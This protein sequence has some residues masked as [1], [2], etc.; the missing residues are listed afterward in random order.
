[1]AAIHGADAVVLV[2]E[3]TQIIDLDWEAVV[4]GLHDPKLVVD[5]RNVLDPGR[6]R[7]AGAKFESIGRV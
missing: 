7:D 4:A 3:W 1:M 2:T 5:G 6:L